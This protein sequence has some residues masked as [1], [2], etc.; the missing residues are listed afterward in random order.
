MK[1]LQKTI[2]I[3]FSVIFLVAMPILAQGVTTANING[4]VQSTEGESL[5]AANVIVVHEPSG[6]QYGASTNSDGRFF[7]PNLK[8]G[9]PYIVTVSYV[10][11]NSQVRKNINLKIGQKL[12]L[13]FILV[14]KSVKLGEVVI[15]GKKY[16]IIN[17]GRTGAE[18]FI[19]PASVQEM[20]SIKR[21][22]RD[23]T[24]LDPRSDGNFSFGGKNWLFN[25]VSV[26]GSYFNNPFGLDDPAPGGQANAEPI[27]F[28]AVEQVQVSIAPFDVREGGFTGAGINI[29]T[30]SGTNKFKGSVYSFL[31]NES[32]IGNKIRGNDVIA[33]PDLSFN[34]SGFY[35]SGPLIKNKLFFFI[36]SE[37]ERREDPGTN[38]VADDDGNIVFGEARVRASIMD[39]IRQRMI[40]SYGYDPG[41]YQGYIHSTKNEKFIAK[42]DWNIN[43]NNNLTFRYNRLDARREQGPHPFVLSINNTGRGPNE[44]SLPFDKSGYRINNRLNSFALELNS[45]GKSFAN[46][47]F[48]SYNKFKDFRDPFSRDFPT[49]EIAVNGVN[50]TTLGHEPFSIHNKLDQEVIQITN[51]YSLFFGKHIFTIGANFEKFKFFNSF[52]IFRDGVF[53]L[54]AGVF[55]GAAFSSLADFFALTDPNNPNFLDFNSPFFIGSGPFKGEDISL[56]QLSFY[57]QDEYFPSNNFSLTYGIRVDIPQYYTDLVDN[58]F[59]RGLT[60]LDENDQPETVDQS[61]LPGGKALFSPRVGFNW[62]V[63][64]NSVTQVRGGT[65][66]FTGRLP[67]VWVGNNISNPGGNPN[68]PGHL[69]S[70]DLNAM[71]PDFKWPQVW[72][73][74]IAIDHLFDN[75]ILG[76]FEFIYGKDI[77]AIFVRNADLVTPVRTLPDG[78]PY[79]GGFGNNELNPDGGA[80][81]YVIDNTDEGYNYSFTAQLRKN[82]ENGVKVN[83]SYTFL[84][85]KNVMKTTE[86]ASVLW[87]NN[88][89]KGDPNKPQLSDAE[90]GKRHRIIGGLTYKK[91]WSENYT[92]SIG[93]FLEIAEGNR[94]TAAGGN[95]YS[96]IY[97]GDVNG[98]GQGGND[99]IYIPR[100]Q[101]EIN[102]D[103]Y[104]NSSGQ[105]VTA[106]DQWATFNSFISQDDYL[107]SNR[108]S[109]ADRFGEI[110]P[111][112]SN[113]DLRI[114]QDFSFMMGNSKQTFQLSI[115]IL[116]VANL[117]NSEWGVRKIANA[118]ATSPLEL[119]R[120][121][122]QGAPVF[123]YKANLTE[124]FSDDLG[125][126]SRWSMQVGLRYIF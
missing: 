99:L 73:T 75:G 52:N 111:W 7:L 105:T 77:N 102:F 112:F 80:G 56:G 31:R 124:T 98:D 37:I 38:F 97:A 67:F 110:N 126:F 114:L 107:N 27:P 68:L 116:N 23:L 76:T 16:E 71:V 72:T 69:Q 92:T 83:L 88:P 30:K 54:P 119:V 125:Q 11:Y 93:V 95:R 18:T 109:I 35:F 20:P 46:K 79:F 90:F 28:D 6:T 8:I 14:S 84:K 63:N 47:F 121:D 5:I 87:Q 50:Y 32:L 41:Q 36:N 62:D 2:L 21:S 78:R 17:S 44:N 33:N 70:F 91:E 81:A 19:D 108:G 122:S 115:D 29:V 57:A 82:F 43:E 13:N 55:T 100:N 42:I 10:G 65:G 85:A 117:I 66:I 24:R 25:N 96:F 123:N 48:A 45:R 15:V 39:S 120:F 34:Q 64:G 86:I 89:V 103:P 58:P 53:F 26:D 12:N 40:S 9:G 104:V 60:L 106:A 59:S 118:L 101:N 49:V 22:T 51:N 74:N 3:I 94:F 4:L 61:V 113:I 1:S